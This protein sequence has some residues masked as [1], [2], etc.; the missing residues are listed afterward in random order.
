MLSLPETGER[1]VSFLRGLAPEIQIREIDVHASI[2]A[3]SYG[4]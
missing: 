4:V 1:F 3:R 2:V